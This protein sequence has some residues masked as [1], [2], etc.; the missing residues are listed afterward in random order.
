MSHVHQS[1]EPDAEGASEPYLWTDKHCGDCDHCKPGPATTEDVMQRVC[2]R[3]PPTVTLA[4]DA[5]G[6]PAAITFR[7]SVRVDTPACGDFDEKYVAPG[8]LVQAS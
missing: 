1:P 8:K 7:P 3:T 5:N 6:R 4:A 2:Y